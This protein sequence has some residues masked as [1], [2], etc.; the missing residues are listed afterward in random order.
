M[1]SCAVCIEA[2]LIRRLFRCLLKLG[3]NAE[4]MTQSAKT[5]FEKNMPEVVEAHH[6][7]ER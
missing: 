6:A 2:E 7:G 5:Y 3:K 1:Y 4:L